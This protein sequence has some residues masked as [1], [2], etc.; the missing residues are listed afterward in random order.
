M[1]ETVICQ[2]RVRPGAEEDFTQLLAHH[3]PTLR[4]LELVTDA[5]AR[6]YIG[7]E[8]GIDGPLFVEI[9]EWVEGDAA[10]RAHTHPEV[11][12][13]WERMELL[14]EERNGRPAMDFPHFKP[15]ELS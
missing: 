12:D 11:S 5:P 7:K 4:S 2:Y 8:R 15:L 13:I 3:V 14:C 10:R 9:F 6:C 1:T